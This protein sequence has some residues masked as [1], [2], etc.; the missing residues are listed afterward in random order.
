MIS[1][2]ELLE[3]K[4]NNQT[5]RIESFGTN[6]RGKHIWTVGDIKLVA[7]RLRVLEQELLGRGKSV[8][9]I[10]S[11]KIHPI[12]SFAAKMPWDAFFQI[13]DQGDLRLA[14]TYV[15]NAAKPLRVVWIGQEPS[16]E[17]YKRLIASTDTT[18]IGYGPEK[19][20]EIWD[21]IFFS[22]DQDAYKVE[23]TLLSRMGS[24]KLAA[25][26]LK[27]VIPELKAACA[28][29]VW[30][31]IGESEKS[32]SVFWYDINDGEVAQENFDFHE[33]ADFLRDLA[34]RICR[35]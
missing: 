29:L 33:A 26:N 2:K 21:A 9:I 1:R 4:M 7:N 19:P 17:V 8:L 10:N 22:G 34:E 18:V 28:G 16:G 14:L 27:S 20:R 6:L 13:R 32:G 24:T 30:S 12:P 31:C 25:C 5:I 15:A 3:I 35:Q 11:T 23:E